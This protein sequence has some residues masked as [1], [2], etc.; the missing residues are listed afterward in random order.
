MGKIPPLVTGCN[1]ELSSSEELFPLNWG[2]AS[3]ERFILSLKWDDVGLTRLSWDQKI[4]RHF[5]CDQKRSILPSV[6]TV[7][8]QLI[9]AKGSGHSPD[10]CGQDLPFPSLRGSF[11]PSAN[12]QIQQLKIIL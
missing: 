8:E 2:T 5:V 10:S 3:C 7:W 9:L 4:K 1:L 12:Q 6:R 11:R